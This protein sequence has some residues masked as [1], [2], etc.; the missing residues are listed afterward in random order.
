[1]DFSDSGV[2]TLMV[3]ESYTST[4]VCT[5]LFTDSTKALNTNQSIP[6]WPA[7]SACLSFKGPDENRGLIFSPNVKVSYDITKV[8]A[9]GPEYYGSTGPFFNYDPIQQQQHQLF[10]ATDLNFSPVWEFNAGY[11]WGFT[12]ATDRSI[13]KVILGRRF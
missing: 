11:G 6:P 7:P 10:I 13:F 12:D 1:M 9:I 5:L 3:T 2:I 8:I 4:G